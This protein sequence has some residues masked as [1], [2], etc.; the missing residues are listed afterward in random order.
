MTLTINGVSIGVLSTVKPTFGQHVVIPEL[1]GAAADPYHNGNVRRS[2]SIEI[3]VKSGYAQAVKYIHVFRTNF[4]YVTIANDDGPLVGAEY[5]I[6][7]VVEGYEGSCDFMDN[8]VITL[9]VVERSAP[10]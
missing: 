7:C 9:T 6:V 8:G 4:A 5:S 1:P 2:F 10:L 3:S